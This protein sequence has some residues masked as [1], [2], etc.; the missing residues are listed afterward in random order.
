[1]WQRDFVRFRKCRCQQCFV[2]FFGLP[3]L[4]PTHPPESH[5]GHQASIFV[6]QGCPG[7]PF[8][9]DFWV[10]GVFFC[11]KK[12]FALQCTTITPGRIE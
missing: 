6:L 4:S 2:A 12:R 9:I 8:V 5:F 10:S 11:K 1:V 7:D 3:N